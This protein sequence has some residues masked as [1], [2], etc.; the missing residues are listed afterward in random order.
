MIAQ[1][2]SDEQT[3]EAYGLS[4]ATYSLG[5]Q[6]RL[7]HATFL[8][9]SINWLTQHCAEM[10]PI[11]APQIL[12]LGCGNGDFDIEF[13]KN[14]QRTRPD[15]RFTGLDYNRTDLDEFR[16]ALSLSNEEIK[17]RVSLEYKKFD[18]TT[19]LDQH[20][21]LIVMVHFLHS[22]DNVLP[23]IRNALKHLN[24]GG[25]LLIIQ[26]T[27]QGIYEIKSKFM[28][29]LPN[30]KFQS[31]DR[32]KHSLKTNE[33]SF[34]AQTIDT[35][36]DISSLQNMSLDALL[37][38]SFCFNNDLS[39][40]NTQQQNEIREAFLSYAREQNNG[41]FTIYEPMEAIVCQA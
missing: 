21:D 29:F 22:F 10:L 33:I 1:E 39:R 37:L 19:H 16:K 7:Q 32:I 18:H 15:L 6:L 28:D 40:L 31:S 34:T 24:P 36:F 13:L 25:R 17:S 11:E 23:V 35:Y 30:Q 9:S 3:I 4:E 38:M 27:E 20:F 12:S 41:P 5:Y 2:R 26:Q 14:C 8:Q